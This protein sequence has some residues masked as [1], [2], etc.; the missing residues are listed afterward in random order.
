MTVF[1]VE[2][3]KT[4]KITFLVDAENKDHAGEVAEG[5]TDSLDDLDWDDYGAWDFNVQE[6][7]VQEEVTYGGAPAKFPVWS[8]RKLLMTPAMLLEEVKERNVWVGGPK[9]G[10]ES[11]LEWQKPKPMDPHQPGPGQGSLLEVRHEDM[12]LPPGRPI[13]DGPAL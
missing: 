6:V 13:E 7:V 9:G 3:E 1:K 12:D 4:L 11:D 10:W 2:V 8:G 5:A